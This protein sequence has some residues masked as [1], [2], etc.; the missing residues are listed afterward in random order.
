MTNCIWTCDSCNEAHDR[1]LNASKN[2]LKQG[3]NIISGCG[4]QSDKKQKRSKALPLGES[5]TSEAQPIGSAVG[6]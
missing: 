4:I 1:D 5:V 2:I 6:G 3:L